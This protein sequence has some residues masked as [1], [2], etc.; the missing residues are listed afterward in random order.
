MP[1]P[2]YDIEGLS[3]NPS[4][5]K[6]HETEKIDKNCFLLELKRWTTDFL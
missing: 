1:D 2:C 3:A 6:N 4:K 5:L